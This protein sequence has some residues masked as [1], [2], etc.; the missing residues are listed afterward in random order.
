MARGQMWGKPNFKTLKFDITGNTSFL[1]YTK[2]YFG[3]W[4]YIG[5]KLS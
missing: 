5:I 1:P 3:R 4:A 2:V